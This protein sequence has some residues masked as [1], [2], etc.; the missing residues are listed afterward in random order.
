[1][2]LVRRINLMRE[3]SREARGTGKKIALVPTMGAL[4][5]GHLS[6][7]H[8]ARDMADLVVVSVF[9]N[10]LQFGPQE[11]LIRYPRDL[12]R[13]T[14]LCIQEGV[15]LLFVPEAEE[16]YPPSF[17][18]FVEVGGLSSVFEGAS[19][20]GHFR[21]VT[22]IVLKLLNIVRPHFSVFGQKDAQQVQ[23]IR[24]MLRDL[25]L[26]T[27]LLVQPTRRHEDG[28][29]MSSRNLFL[30][31]DDRRAACVLFKALEHG[32]QLVQTNE[33][34]DLRHLEAGI[35]K[36]IDSEERVKLDYLAAVN[37]ETLQPPA[38]LNEDLLILVAA[39]VGGTRL[40]DNIQVR[41]AK[42]PLRT[43]TGGGL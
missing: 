25:N 5:D 15:D 19:R 21:G 13:D 36:V 10:P 39:W 6:L 4:H 38:G 26:D 20:P 22:T 33:A 7:V 35:R 14:D 17:S 2:E 28:L 18:T 12:A 43:P 37:P 23:V 1:M 11:D 31:A 41:V 16:M 30:S 32:R 42:G 9:V 24:R 27:E 29:A 34:R 3:M 8:R 40:I